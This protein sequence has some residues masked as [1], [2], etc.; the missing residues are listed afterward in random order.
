MINVLF[1]SLTI[2]RIPLIALCW[3]A[4]DQ[5]MKIHV[6]MELIWM[7]LHFIFCI[8]D[9]VFGHIP[10]YWHILCSISVYSGCFHLLKEGVLPFPLS[11]GG[12]DPFHVHCCIIKVQQIGYRVLHKNVHWNHARRIHEVYAKFQGPEL[13]A[14]SKLS[15]PY[16]K[17]KLTFGLQFLTCHTN[18]HC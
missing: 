15:F 16:V 17:H 1:Y 8:C 6:Q 9:P 13:W 18:I 2:R 4:F 5:K 3:N 7:P 10:Q 11:E 12:R 14:Y